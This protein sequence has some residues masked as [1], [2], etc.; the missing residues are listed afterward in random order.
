MSVS[1]DALSVFSAN[2]APGWFLFYTKYTLVTL[3]RS[4]R[5]GT[6]T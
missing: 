1:S 6:D 3:G 5:H 4:S 2:P